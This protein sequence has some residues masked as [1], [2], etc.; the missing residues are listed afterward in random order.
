VFCGLRVQRYIF[1]EYQQ[2]FFEK[3]FIFLFYR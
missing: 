2:I 3:F 1:F